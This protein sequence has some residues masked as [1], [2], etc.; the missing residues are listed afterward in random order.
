MIISKNIPRLDECIIFIFGCV[1]VA[2]IARGI[3]NIRTTSYL[4]EKPSMI[5]E[6]LKLTVANV[7]EYVWN[8]ACCFILFKSGHSFLLLAIAVLAA[9]II[10]II[11]IKV[12]LGNNKTALINL[13]EEAEAQKQ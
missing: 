3:K 8:F 12:K 4:C 7:I 6:T 2:N 1:G 10:E 11:G 13:K 5:W 9:V